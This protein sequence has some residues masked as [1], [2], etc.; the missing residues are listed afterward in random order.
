[1]HHRAASRGLARARDANYAAHPARVA[2]CTVCSAL[3]HCLVSALPATRA[4]MHET[5]LRTSRR[6]RTKGRAIAS[7]CASL[8][9]SRH[10]RSRA[11]RASRRARA[12][13]P[14]R[15]SYAAPAGLR[16]DLARDSRAAPP[17]DTRH[18]LPEPGAAPRW[19]AV[20]S[21][22]DQRGWRGGRQL[23]QVEARADADVCAQ[24]APRLANR[25]TP[26]PARASLPR[27]VVAH[28]AV[29]RVTAARSHGRPRMFV[30]GAQHQR[31]H[32]RHQ[33]RRTGRRTAERR[34]AAPG[35]RGTASDSGVQ[36]G[37]SPPLGWAGGPPHPKNRT[38]R[39]PASSPRA[40][41]AVPT[42]RARAHLLAPT[43]R[44]AYCTRTTSCARRHSPSRL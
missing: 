27:G 23:E 39:R 33:W 14:P 28:S 4:T 9:G 17:V 36:G 6:R 20:R 18:C 26:A 10:A 44:N 22:R 42:Q 38:A 11:P 21:A 32:S 37:V 24:H 16:A 3:R 5:N 15:A 41:P 25:R 40:L 34:L 35:H 12:P 43:A 13:A 2:A 31:E 29:P 1:M 30:R 19:R 8:L 7:G